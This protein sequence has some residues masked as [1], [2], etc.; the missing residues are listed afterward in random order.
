M[1]KLKSET[2]RSASDKDEMDYLALEHEYAK[3]GQIMISVPIS[4]C[5]RMVMKGK[6]LI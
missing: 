6:G 1:F 5:F 3:G 4:K 2:V